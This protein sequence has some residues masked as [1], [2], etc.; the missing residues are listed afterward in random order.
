MKS[1]NV[2]RVLEIGADYGRDTVF[3]ATNGL[4]VEANIH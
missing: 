1:N 4:E 2:K 3:F